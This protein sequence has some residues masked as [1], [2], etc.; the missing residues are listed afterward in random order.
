MFHDES[1]LLGR[2]FREGKD[3]GDD[4]RGVRHE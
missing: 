1:E 3:V 4:A 2:P